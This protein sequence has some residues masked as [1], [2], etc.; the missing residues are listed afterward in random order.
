MCFQYKFSKT[1]QTVCEVIPLWV[2]LTW[3][4]DTTTLKYEHID[5]TTR[6][7][8]KL[9]VSEL[10]PFKQTG[11]SSN[12]YQSFANV[13]CCVP[14]TQTNPLSHVT[15]QWLRLSSWLLFSQSLQTHQDRFV[16][17]YRL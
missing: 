16:I 17:R 6:H 1:F 7:K 15:K 8:V 10:A 11:G 5:S 3:S 13:F 2:S 4:G 9:S 14:P 12:Q